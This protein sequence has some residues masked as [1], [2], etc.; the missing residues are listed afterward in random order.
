MRIERL[1]LIA[2]G[3]FDDHSLDLKGPGVH[4]V[5]GPNEAGKSTTL[6]ALDQLLY[7]MDHNARYAFRH[8]NR[9]RL[10]ARLSAAGGVAL[11]II[12]Q[13][14]RKNALVDADGTPLTEEALVPFLGGV[15]RRTFTTEIALNSKELRRGGELLASGEGD[16]AQLLAAARSGLRLNAALKKI[17]ERQRVLYLKTGKNPR[18]NDGLGRLK[19]VRQELRDATLR[20]EQYRNAEQAVAE[21]EQRLKAVTAELKGKKRLRHDKWQ[22]RE[23]LPA[24][25]RYHALEQQTE[26]I[27]AQ[28]PAAPDD[29][30]E[31]LPGLIRRQGERE[32]VRS[33][34]RK[35]AERVE[36]QLTEAG[37]D[38][39]LLRYDAV[40]E[41]L[42]RDV[43]AILDVARQREE[44]S[45]EAARTRARAEA[46]LRTVHP[47]ATLADEKLYRVSPALLKQGQ[48]LR[49]EGR[50]CRDDLNRARDEV[51]RWQEKC[52]QAGKNLSALP[53]LEDVSQLRNA[54]SVVPADLLTKLADTKTREKKLGRRFRQARNRL[55]FPEMEPAEVLNLRLPERE[56][57]TEAENAFRRLDQ[58]EHE[59]TAELDRERRQLAAHRRELARLVS[60]DAPPTH[61]EVRALR[62]RRDELLAEFLDDPSGDTPLQEAVKRA[63]DTVDLMLRHVEQVNRRANLEREIADLEAV[64][65]DH[66]AAVEAVLA[67]RET[68]R[69]SWEELWEAWPATTP[70]SAQASGVLVDFDKL[71]SDAQ[72]LQDVRIDLGEQREHLHAHIAR[73]Q[74]LLR[75]DDDDPQITVG[76]A[77]ASARLA[78]MM[79]MAGGRLREHETVATDLAAA[80]R[81]LATAESELA[82]AE[83]TATRA[84]EA[85]AVHHEGGQRFLDG[86]GLPADRDLDTALAD[87]ESL[88]AVAADVGSAAEAERI[89]TKSGQRMSEFSRLM[90]DTLRACGRS[91]PASTSGWQQAVDTL[92]R[93]LQEQRED[94]QLREGLLKNKSE[95][96]ATV[97]EAD[98]ELAGLRSRLEGFYT[99]V[100]VSSLAELEAAAA[101]AT[102]LR[103]KYTAIDNLRQTLPEG[104]ELALIRRQAEQT[105]A[106][107]LDAELTD[108]DEEIHGL[109]TSQADWLERRT[110]RRQVLEGLDGS[111]DAASAAADVAQICAELAE[112]A[113]EYLRLE[114]ARITILACMEEYR[115]S[116]QEPVLTRASE[117][118][119]EL[120]RGRY[121]ALELSD[122]ERPSIRAKSSA[123]T[124]LAPQDLSEGTTDQLYLALRL[125]TLERHAVAGSALPIAVDDIFMTFD[126]QR[127]EAALR[128]LDGMADRFQVIVFTHH[129]YVIRSAAKSLPEGHC[130]VHQLPGYALSG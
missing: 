16:M 10:G 45:D 51:E 25:A 64:I 117:V 90:E 106:Q 124:L 4:L 116:D 66:Q 9:T 103:E 72:E 2:Y 56:Q 53:A 49:D 30:R 5:H 8:G 40:I 46:R 89:V 94:A 109:E 127:T 41:Q 62:A 71:K 69:Q 42:T 110:E 55:D 83:S 101:R 73:L 104:Q 78:E 61:E 86:A 59:H 31:E 14:K 1:D 125:A 84:Q 121:V 91:V 6:S 11:E 112:D 65:P 21:A 75:L 60:D 3:V 13:K 123:G 119:R 38:D 115:T 80:Q 17:E 24:L 105:S 27:R 26:E 63:D 130:H 129:E 74:R 95:L 81:D 114:T 118:F 99:R 54:H 98:A 43:T 122:E 97:A 76:T 102:E 128:V 82:E 32:A 39:S 23:K 20:P 77:H 100:G 111:G 7:G 50:K 28:G 126:E 70:E 29:I 108:L 34:D 96:A 67:E 58:R 57:V 48:E 22:L 120:S 87:L 37:K 18:I 52:E 12:R 113:E 107:E 19:A 93:D 33:R 68:A 92:A 36:E 44:L 15:D 85:V 88:L 35:V 47:H 79:E